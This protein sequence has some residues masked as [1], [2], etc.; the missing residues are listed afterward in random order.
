MTS[1]KIEF[2]VNGA[3]PPVKRK[4]G[5]PKGST[6]GDLSRVIQAVLGWG[7]YRPHLFHIP[8]KNVTAQPGKPSEEEGF[9]YEEKMSLRT[10]KAP[11]TYVYGFGTRWEVS[12]TS[13]KQSNNDL[14]APVLLESEGE[15]PLEDCA[16][17]EAWNDILRILANPAHPDYKDVKAWADEVRQAGDI[18]SVNARLAKLER[19]DD[20]EDDLPN[21]V[22]DPKVSKGH[23][24]RIQTDPKTLAF[25]SKTEKSDSK[26]LAAMK[27][28]CPECGSLCVPAIDKD[29]PPVS[30]SGQAHY[31]I[32]IEC[33]CGAS[34]GLSLLNDSYTV[35][36]TYIGECHPYPMYVRHD[37]IRRE[38]RKER[39]P[40]RRGRLLL[41]LARE[42]VL[43][44]EKDYVPDE[45]E[46]AAR[47]TDSRDFAVSSSARMDL[48]CLT[49]VPAFGV[50]MFP[51]LDPVSDTFYHVTLPAKSAAAALDDYKKVEK[52]LS[53]PAVP[54]WIR[55]RLL[56]K[57]VARIDKAGDH[58]TAAEIR[59]DLLRTLIDKAKG[60]DADT[61][62]F[63][64]IV[65]T[66]ASLCSDCYRG[67]IIKKAVE[68]LDMYYS[69]FASDQDPPSP[70]LRVDSLVRMGLYRAAVL[71]DRKNAKKDLSAA[72]RMLD[73]SPGILVIKRAVVAAA[74]QSYID[75]KDTESRDLS[76]SLSMQLLELHYADLRDVNDIMRLSLLDAR[77][78]ED[79]MSLLMMGMG[80]MGNDGVDPSRRV[81]R[82]DDAWSVG[83]MTCY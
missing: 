30:I 6:L 52:S 76:M 36:Y 3:E 83:F 58:S 25:L 17:I 74:L 59:T 72:I 57:A 15:A 80:A 44:D 13:Q 77:D 82:I 27:I 50:I 79:P 35:G 47:V 65:D 62:T 37:S 7:D 24:W 20:D 54:E 64:R 42:S 26:K 71:K 11:M 38:L 5:L 16:G 75:V 69:A 12:V 68:G 10:Y 48:M 78:R 66:V 61:E 1:Y 46:E 70:I 63:R 53:D 8:A 41:S 21:T 56:L 32:R 55:T 81:R 2:S 14:D 18:D 23:N 73:R 51:S 29:G 43:L 22:R 45:L 31:Q 34:T 39:N 28:P 49:K 67:G 4:V 33:P 60:P 19:P 40:L 9:F